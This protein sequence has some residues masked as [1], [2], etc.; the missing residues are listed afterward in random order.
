MNRSRKLFVYIFLA[1]G[2]AFCLIPFIWLIRS[3]VMSET[4]MFSFPPQLI[5]DPFKWSNY[6][7]AFTKVPFGTYFFNTFKIEVVYLVGMLITCTLSA[8]SF[9][10]LQW[11][12]RNVIFA[13]ILSAIMLPGAVVLIPQFL[14]WK[15]LNLLDTIA[16]L[17]VPG[18]LGVGGILYMFLLRQFFMTIPKDLDEAV[19]MDGGSPLTF[20]TRILIPLSVPAYIAIAIM[21]FCGVW[22][23]LLGPLIYLNSAE[24]YTVAVGLTAFQTAFRTEWGMLMAAAT[25]ATAPLILIFFFLQRYFIEGITLTGI[26]G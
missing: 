17:T 8:Y 26:K 7:N 19:Y 23:D 15:T 20:L 25:A 9:A 11:P 2:A 4:Q 3:S 13:V 12:L 18:W 10:R 5:P 16:P 14:F 24:N 1:I 6:K 21:G 22:N